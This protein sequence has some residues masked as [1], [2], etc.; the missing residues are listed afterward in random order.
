MDLY[1]YLYNKYGGNCQLNKLTEECAELIVA[2]QH[3]HNG[4]IDADDV[5]GEIADVQICLETT[6]LYL[7]ENGNYN[8]IYNDKMIRIKQREG[9]V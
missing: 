7:N 3:M 6:K 9:L 1:K 2:I 4:R 5:L 8:R